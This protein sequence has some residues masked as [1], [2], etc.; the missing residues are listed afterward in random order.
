MV[1]ISPRKDLLKVELAFQEG[2]KMAVAKNQAVDII[3]Y[4]TP[5]KTIQGCC[6]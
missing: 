2:T 5:E 4:T 3:L 1:D 6:F